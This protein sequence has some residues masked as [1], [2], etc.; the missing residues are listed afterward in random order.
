MT[1]KIKKLIALAILRFRL[2]KSV[3]IKLDIF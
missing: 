3:Q 2:I 1:T